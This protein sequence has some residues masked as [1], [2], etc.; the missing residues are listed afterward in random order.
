MRNREALQKDAFNPLFEI[1]DEVV[2]EDAAIF[3]D[4]FNPL[5]EI[6]L[7]QGGRLRVKGVAFNPLFEIP[8]APRR[9]PACLSRFQ[10]SF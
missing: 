8:S 10:S 2:A 9:L 1:P 5:F 4:A 3:E 6:H 7:T